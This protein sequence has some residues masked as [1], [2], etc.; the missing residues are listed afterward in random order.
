MIDVR[1]GR[2]KLRL[3]DIEIVGTHTVGS[4]K[5]S[6][7]YLE[8]VLADPAAAVL[9]HLG[10][11]LVVLALSGYGSVVDV[12]LGRR[13]LDEGEEGRGRAAV[14]AVDV[15]GP[16]GLVGRVLGRLPADGQVHVGRWPL[17]AKGGP[18]ARGP[19]RVLLVARMAPWHDPLAPP[20][21]NGPV[22]RA[23]HYFGSLF[24]PRRGEM[25][26]RRRFIMGLAD[27]G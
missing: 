15:Q 12:D 4:E 8:T 11:E 17:A 5:E 2:R 10:P 20:A 9:D 25:T 27:S 16:S 13:M 18:V 21:C 23:A 19:Q 14:G 6:A 22:S 26:I 1:T 7:K 24:G 3:G